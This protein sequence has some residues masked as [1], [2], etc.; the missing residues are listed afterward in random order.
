V[1]LQQSEVQ[2]AGLFVKNDLS[3]AKK[4]CEPV[5]LHVETY[6]NYLPKRTWRQKALYEVNALK[7]LEQRG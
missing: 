2:D 6:R 4:V 1:F 3:R 5:K 7:L